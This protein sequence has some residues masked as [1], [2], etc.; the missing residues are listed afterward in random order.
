M[1][2]GK[3]DRVVHG[4]VGMIVSIKDVQVCEFGEE[5]IVNIELTHYYFVLREKL[6]LDK[7]IKQKRVQT[8]QTRINYK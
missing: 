2:W 4:I 6:G 7:E 8:K 3:M 1:G 5:G